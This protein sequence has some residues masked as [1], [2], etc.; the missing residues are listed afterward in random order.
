ML[1]SNTRIVYISLLIIYIFIF[2]YIKDSNVVYPQWIYD[3]IS[4]T[5]YICLVSFTYHETDMILVLFL[6]VLSDSNT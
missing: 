4:Y 2:V 3:T 6:L 5:D 1:I